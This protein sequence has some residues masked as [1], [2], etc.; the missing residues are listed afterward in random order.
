MSVIQVQSRGIFHGLPVY[1]EAEGLTAV[2]TGANGI[3]GHYVLRVLS[4]STHRWKKIYCLSRRPPA[5]PGGL[6]PN[7]EHI[8]LDFLQEPDVIAKSL[9][10]QGISHIDYVFFFSYLQPAPK[11]GAGLWSDVE[12]MVRL[13]S[14]LLSNFLSAMPL[15]SLSPKRIMLQTGA[16][17]Y[18]GHFGPTKQP[19][20]ESQ[21]RISETEYEPNFYYSQED[22]LFKHCSNHPQTTWT[23]AMPGPILGAVPDAAMNFAFPLAIYAAISHHLQTPFEFPGDILSWQTYYSISSAHLDAY[24]EEYITLSPDP[25]VANQKFNICDSSSFT[26]EYA[27]PH[28]GAWFGLA[29]A[30]IQGPE[31]DDLTAKDTYPISRYSRFPKPPRGYGPPALVQAKF[32]LAEWAKRPEVVKA[33]NELAE[34]HGLGGQYR[35]LAG[36]KMDAQRIFAF[37][38]RTLCRGAALDLR[39]VLV[40]F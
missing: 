33:W 39:Y 27:W 20:V 34:R 2:I 40:L 21:S 31:K 36:E 11:P 22:I 18:G 26:W 14:L 25:N 8:P 3:S 35:D 6:P 4:E 30:Q 19:S 5:I 32:T 28:I 38:D 17:N 9:Q 10:A 24:F 29:E 15:A 23:I 13:N 1:T 12:E 37:L 16:K 7:A